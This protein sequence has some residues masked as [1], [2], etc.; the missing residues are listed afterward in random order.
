MASPND[1]F[2]RNPMDS[3]GEQMGQP[4]VPL[5]KSQSCVPYGFRRKSTN[6]EKVVYV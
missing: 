5:R 6:T 2:P 1:E 4:A 3:S